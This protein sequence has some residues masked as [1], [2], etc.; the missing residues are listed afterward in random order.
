MPFIKQSK[1]SL[2]TA[3]M[4]AVFFGCS[5]EHEAYLT[6][7]AGE[8]ALGIEAVYER[9]ILSDETCSRASDATIISVFTASP[10]SEEILTRLPEVKYIAT[11]STGFDHIDLAAT[12]KRGVIVSNVPSYGENTVAEHAFGLL[13]GLSKKIYAGFDQIRE[14]GDFNFDAL[15]GFDLKGKTLGVVGT[16]R[17]GCH[18]IAIAKGFGMNVVAYDIAPSPERAEQF[19][20]TYVSLDELLAQSDVVT[21]HVI[22]TPQTHHLIHAETIAK[23]KRGAVLI[24]TSRGAVIDTEALIQGLTSGQLGGAGLDVLE[25]EGVIQDEMQFVLSGKSEGHDL[26]T[27]LAN[28]VLID[29]DNV[30]ITPHIAFNTKEAVERI[31]ETTL[32]NIEAFIQGTPQNI[33]TNA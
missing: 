33:V 29:L 7:R 19:G 20:F 31:L 22:H 5:A 21:L 32:D 3:N 26:R 13:L 1:R 24:N 8:R 2:E 17:I 4:K 23:M 14:K 18:S 6:R 25:E 12:S 30:I 27:V 10:V 11:R 28:H 16:G 15:Q 9:E